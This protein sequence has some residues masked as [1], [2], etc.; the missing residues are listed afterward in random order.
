[1]ITNDADN[2]PVASSE[3]MM[4][5]DMDP[6]AENLSMDEINALLAQLRRTD[7]N[8]SSSAQA[9]EDHPQ[10]WIPNTAAPVPVPVHTLSPLTPP[11]FRH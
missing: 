1:M 2:G 8:D 6:D 4:Q 3:D 10:P 7:E 5:I 11:P 9:L